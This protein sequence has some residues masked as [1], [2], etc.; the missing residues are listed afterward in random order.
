MF[1]D[2]SKNRLKCLPDEI[3]DCYSLTD[4]HL[5]ENYIINLPDTIGNKL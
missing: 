1:I 2:L 4:L 3:G 5:S